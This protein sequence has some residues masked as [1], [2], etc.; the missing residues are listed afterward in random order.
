MQTLLSP[1][2][3]AAEMRISV[4]TITRC[5]KMGAPV[6]RWGSTGKRYRINV[7]EFVAWMEAQNSRVVIMPSRETAEEM[8][9]RRRAAVRAL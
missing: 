3:A 2:E 7:P 8:A 9:R 1:K 6:H 5:V 4:S